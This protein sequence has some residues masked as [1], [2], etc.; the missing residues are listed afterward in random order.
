MDEIGHININVECLTLIFPWKN[1]RTS[2]I[3]KDYSQ[4]NYVIFKTWDEKKNL[5]RTSDRK[6]VQMTSEVEYLFSRCR[7]AIM[8]LYVIHSATHSLMEWLTDQR[9]RNRSQNT[10]YYCD[11]SPCPT[12]HIIA[13]S[14]HLTR[15]PGLLVSFITFSPHLF[16]IGQLNK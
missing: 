8:M 9:Q 11:P 13:Y 14:S 5:R 15:S 7:A 16:S 1:V 4:F 2:V 6:T 12:Y 10:I 3:R